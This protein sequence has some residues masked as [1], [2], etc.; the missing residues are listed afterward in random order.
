[1][2]F[3]S[4]L[5]HIMVPNRDNGRCFTDTQR[6]EKIDSLL[7][8][9]GYRRCNPDGLFFLYSKRPVEEISEPVLISSHIDCVPQMTELFAKDYNE[10]YV[11]GTFDNCI[12]NAAILFLMLNEQLNDD[13]IVAFTGDEECNSNGASQLVNYLS[14][15]HIAPRAT[16]ILDVTD[17]GWE[18]GAS[19]TVE[20][21]FWSDELGK[22]VIEVVKRSN[23]LWKFVPSYVDNI[24]VFIDRSCVIEEEAE[25]DE[26][27]QYD[28]CDYECFSFCLPV[29]GPMHS[30]LGVFARKRSITEY[31][32]TLKNI[33]NEI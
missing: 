28:E 31:I 10:E 11:D 16:I 2:D 15:K 18:N 23:C 14:K 5:Q 19:F 26:S 25:E 13:V 3:Y 8:N 24:P 20:N 29:E 9:T 22:R 6:I 17:M 30:R 7:W 27:W 33:I 12:T 32:D 1:M 4:L 21:N